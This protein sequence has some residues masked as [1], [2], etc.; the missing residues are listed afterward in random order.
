MPS[1]QLKRAEPS[2]Q[3]IRDRGELPPETADAPR[4]LV[5]V[6]RA[7]KGCLS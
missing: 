7:M 5:D 1:S 6:I 4:E 2:T 3:T